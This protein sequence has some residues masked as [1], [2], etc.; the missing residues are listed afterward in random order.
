MTTI[1]TWSYDGYSGT[2]NNQGKLLLPNGIYTRLKNLPN[3]KI[4]NIDLG[5]EIGVWTDKGQIILL[6][7]SEGQWQSA[8]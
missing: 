7:G 5:A 4:I 1:A 2:V 8:L 6:D 3:H